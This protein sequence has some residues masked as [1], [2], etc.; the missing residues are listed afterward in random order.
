VSAL[1]SSAAGTC[2]DSLPGAI[3]CSGGGTGRV[4]RASQNRQ[5]PGSLPAASARP[6]HTAPCPSAPMNA[7]G[8]TGW[9]SLDSGDDDP[10]RFWRYVL[11]A[12]DQAGAAAGAA[13]LRRLDAAGSDVLRDVLPTFVNE[14]TS[15]DAPLV[16]GLDDYHLVTSAQVHT[17]VAALLGHSPPQLHLML[18]TRADP[19]L[20]LSRLRVRGDLAE[21]RAEELRFN[22]GE[23]LEFFS[24]RLGSQLSGRDVLRLL[25]RTEGWAAGLQL[26]ALRLR[27][28]A[29][30]SGFIERFT[31][32]D[33]HIVNYLGDE[34]LTSQTPWCVSSSW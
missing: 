24:E 19:P 9:V 31:G 8:T 34:V 11:L 5:P 22:P 33:W 17:S 18:I 29:D 15:S 26:A 27:G 23:A 21:L 14:L 2:S 28:R 20:P 32:A 12:A 4:S 6:T 1:G 3:C 16:L 7:T 10:K 30:P 13:A 25:A